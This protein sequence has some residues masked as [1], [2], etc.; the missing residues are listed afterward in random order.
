MIKRVTINAEKVAKRTR[1]RM[2]KILPIVLS[3]VNVKGC[4]DSRMAMAPVDIVHSNHAQ[5]K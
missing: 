5:V 2:K 1:S 4:I 3:P